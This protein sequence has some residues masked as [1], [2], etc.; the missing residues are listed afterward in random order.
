VQAWLFARGTQP[1]QHPECGERAGHSAARSSWKR[2]GSFMV[3]ATTTIRISTSD[4]QHLTHV[5]NR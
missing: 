3:V 5:E 1:A 2:K 4:V